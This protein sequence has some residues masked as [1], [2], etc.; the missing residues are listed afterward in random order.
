MFKS[1]RNLLSQ[2]K[3]FTLIEL[4]I[5]ISIIGILATIAVPKF[6]QSQASARTAKIKADLRT[7]DSAIAMAVANGGTLTAGAITAPVSTY[8][9]T[10]PVPPAGTFNVNATT[11]TAG[12]A[13]GVSTVSNR[14]YMSGTTNT[15]TSDFYNA[16]VAQAQK[17]AAAGIQW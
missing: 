8:L 13:Y 4:I 17:D 9:S 16:G 12:A 3:G 11:D 5:V 2:N 1:L 10:V 15:Y 14:A 7:I 6:T